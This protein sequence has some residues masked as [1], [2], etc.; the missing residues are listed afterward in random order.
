MSDTEIKIHKIVQGVV[1]ILGDV[2]KNPGRLSFQENAFRELVH[3]RYLGKNGVNKSKRKEKRRNTLLLVFSAVIVLTITAYF[4]IF[5]I[6]HVTQDLPFWVAGDNGDIVVGELLEA[7]ANRNLDIFFMGGSKVR[8]SPS[9]VAK[10]LESTKKRVLLQLNKG[11]VWVDVEPNGIT[12]WLVLAGLYSVV[13]KGTVFSVNW[14]ERQKNSFGVQVQR[15]IVQVFGPGLGPGGKL[16]SAGFYLKCSKDGIQLSKIENLKKGGK[17]VNKKDAIKAGD[18]MK[19]APLEASISTYINNSGK[20]EKGMPLSLYKA[21]TLPRWKRLCLANK[22]NEAIDIVNSNL[23]RLANR[24]SLVDLWMLADAARFSKKGEQASLLLHSVIKR[25][26]DTR[27]A[28]IAVFLLGR[29]NAELLN[30]P[31]VAAQWFERYYKE[32]S[33]GELAE[34]ALGRAMGNWIRAGDV[35]KALEMAASYISKYPHGVY[36]KQANELL[37]AG[38]EPEP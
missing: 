31:N 3:N 17:S 37:R 23:E 36:F 34:E 9:A 16:V 14:G 1:R 24:L 38:G 30:S 35:S 29:V 5:N 19:R 25:Y 27:H 22:Y 11:K 33:D 28:K 2:P 20:K 12:R 8:L 21:K 26:P 7:P 15:G 10:V 32:N 18:V 4:I 6:T 13:V